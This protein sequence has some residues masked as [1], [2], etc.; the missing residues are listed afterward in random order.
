MHGRLHTRCAADGLF[1]RGDD[2]DEGAHFGPVAARGDEAG[3]AVGAGGEDAVIPCY[4]AAEEGT[5][6]GAGALAGD[7]GEF[8]RG[9][10]ELVEV[11]DG[12]DEGGE[13]GGGGGEAGGCGEV[14]GGGE[15]EGVD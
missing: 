5:A 7:E 9:L 12:A 14:V 3:F 4:V 8:G 11:C 1:L 2:E 15:A 10:G 6:G 13:A